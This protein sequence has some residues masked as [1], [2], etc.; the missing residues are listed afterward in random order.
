MHIKK[1]CVIYRTHK[2]MIV[3]KPQFFIGDSSKRITLVFMLP[4]QGVYQVLGKNKGVAF[5]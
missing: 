5:A 2:R 3:W 4:F 1:P